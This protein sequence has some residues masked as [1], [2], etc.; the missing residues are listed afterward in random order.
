MPGFVDRAMTNCSNADL[1]EIDSDRRRQRTHNEKSRAEE[2][3]FPGSD[4]TIRSAEK[5]N[6]RPEQSQ[7]AGNYQRRR[8]QN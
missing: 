7:D 1:C 2:E 6:K 8:N 3:R 5:A 4:F